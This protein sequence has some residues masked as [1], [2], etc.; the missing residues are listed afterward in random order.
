MRPTVQDERTQGQAAPPLVENPLFIKTSQISVVQ[1]MLPS[2]QLTVLNSSQWANLRAITDISCTCHQGCSW[3]GAQAEEGTRT[4][5]SFARQ[6]GSD[7]EFLENEEFWLMGFF[8]TGRSVAGGEH[9]A[10]RQRT[11]RWGPKR[12]I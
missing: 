8:L 12:G 11:S 3:G 5:A 10:S 4:S 7:R 9:R 1:N 6:A 2:S